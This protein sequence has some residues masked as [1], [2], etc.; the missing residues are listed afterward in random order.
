MNGTRTM[1][2]TTR[3]LLTA[4]AV[5][6]L[7]S[8]TFR[9]TRNTAVREVECWEFQTRQ[10]S[11]KLLLWVCM[12]CFSQV[13]WNQ[14]ISMYGGNETYMQYVRSFHTQAAF[15]RSAQKLRRHCKKASEKLNMDI[16]RYMAALHSNKHY[17]YVLLVKNKMDCRIMGRMCKAVVFANKIRDIL[18]FFSI[19]SALALLAACFRSQHKTLKLHWY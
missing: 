15:T 1:I 18:L 5:D 6:F 13:I 11:W 2:E 4:C 10:R 16:F 3:V 9:R 17:I 14:G 12:L 7:L 8:S 19:I